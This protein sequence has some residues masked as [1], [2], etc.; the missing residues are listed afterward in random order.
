MC[1]EYMNPEEE[2][3]SVFKPLSYVPLSLLSNLNFL[4]GVLW[5]KQASKLQV[6]LALFTLVALRAL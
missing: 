6:V 4:S 5:G 2:V 3:Q 1:C